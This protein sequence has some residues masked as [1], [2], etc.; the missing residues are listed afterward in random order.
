[1]PCSKG[2]G[3][4]KMIFKSKYELYEFHLAP[5]PWSICR[6]QKKNKWAA[7]ESR[8]REKGELGMLR[9]DRAMCTIILASVFVIMAYLI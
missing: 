7:W 9:I 4:C 5:S 2:G 3:L 8:E 1:M 6:F